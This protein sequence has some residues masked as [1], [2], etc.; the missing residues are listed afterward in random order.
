MG[1]QDVS[2]VVGR[3]TLTADRL[4]ARRGE[5]GSLAKLEAVGNTILQHS[6]RQARGDELTWNME[7]DIAVLIGSPAELR[8]GP[9]KLYGDRIE[10]AETA[11]RVRIRSR[12]RVEA[13]LKTSQP[14]HRTL[15]Y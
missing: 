13:T 12:H 5:D 15:R 9:Q 8:D 4:T 10:F 1:G 11:G 2:V 14:L 7:E 3:R 6:G